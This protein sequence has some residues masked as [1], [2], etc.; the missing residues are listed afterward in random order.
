MISSLTL[1]KASRSSSVSTS[2]SDLS[3]RSVPDLT[4]QNLLR[5]LSTS[6]P[7]L[8]TGSFVKKKK[9]E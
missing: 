6:L 9:H 1:F 8:H 7:S 2:L 5:L 4:S 3:V